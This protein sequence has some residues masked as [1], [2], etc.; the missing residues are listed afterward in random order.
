MARTAEKV[1]SLVREDPEMATIL[2]DL[3]DHDGDLQWQDVSDDV[4]SGQWGRLLEK[5]ILVEGDTGFEVGD[6]D[7]VKEGLA[8][9]DDG[10]DDSPEGTSWSTYDKL[11]GVGAV[12]AMIGY[13]YSPI[14]NAIG[15]TINVVLGPLDSIMPFYVVILVLAVLTGLYTTILQANLTDMEKM[16]KYQEQAQELQDKMS[17]AKERGD[18]AAVERLREEQMEAF[19]DQASMMKEQF[20]PMVWIM[21]LTIPVFLW[22]YWKLGTGTIPQSELNMVLPLLGE[23]D[24]NGGR[25]LVF[26]A[27]ILW[28]MMCSFSFSN[29]IRK[30]L[31]IQT[32]PT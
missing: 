2:E 13:S 30:A 15:G 20:R 16:S 17:A 11:A 21:L 29:I 25:V 7:G 1:Q 5:D 3:L 22:M 8:P 27:W 31:N 28:Y 6:P 4:S 12:G 19:G 10:D 18:D 14:K 9:D 23:I 32:T 24:L 26:P